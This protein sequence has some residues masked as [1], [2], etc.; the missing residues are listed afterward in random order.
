MRVGAIS[1]PTPPCAFRL[2]L[3]FYL[4]LLL[5]LPLLSMT[6]GRKV[7]DHMIP[8]FCADVPADVPLR[9]RPCPVREMRGELSLLAGARGRLGGCIPAQ[10]GRVQGLS[11][12]VLDSGLGR[13]WSDLG[14]DTCPTPVKWSPPRRT[15]PRRSLPLCPDLTLPPCLPA[16]A[17]PTTPSGSSVALCSWPIDA[18]GLR[19]PASNDDRDEPDPLPWLRP[20][21][22]PL[23]TL[24]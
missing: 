3:P 12:L 9:L 7:F 14:C 24:R 13:P 23:H 17:Q 2:S 18:H 4:T 6:A 8:S 1:E 21:R 19:R 11:P 5:L 16:C 15:P 20:T 22:E 10:L